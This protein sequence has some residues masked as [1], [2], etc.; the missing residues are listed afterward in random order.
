MIIIVSAYSSGA[1]LPGFFLERHHQCIHVTTKREWDIARLRSYFNADSFV[2]NYIIDN[3]QEFAAVLDELK[4]HDIKAILPGCES[5]VELF[6][7]LCSYFSVPAND[8]QLSAARRNKYLMIEA[9]KKHGLLHAKQFKSNDLTELL[10]WFKEHAK[11][12]VVLKPLSSSSSDGV[13]YCH[14]EAEITN[15]FNLI[16]HQL[17]MY[18]MVNH[19][20]L[21]Q[22]FLDGDEYIVNS[23]SCDGEHYVVDIWKGVSEDSSIVSNDI[24][25]DLVSQMADEYQQLVDY[26]F[27]VLDALGIKNGPAHSEVRITRD[28]PCLI[29][30]GARLAGKVDFSVINTIFGFSQLSLT[31]EVILTP[32]EFKYRIA[33]KK[34]NPHKFARYV[35]FFS[36]DEGWI[37]Q[38]PDLSGI[39]ALESVASVQFIYH[40]G[41]YLKKTSKATK[42]PR[43]GY[44]YLVADTQEQLERDYAALRI[45][46][47][48][49]YAAI[50][51]D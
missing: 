45:A 50:L 20:V 19:E 46:E 33:S 38:E 23:V 13:F 35:Y 37:K 14:N 40:K 16:M 32:D 41:Q 31:G 18:H 17:D 2:K 28:G 9:I 11:S 7:K 44:A 34:N 39:V 1:S 4:K 5:G 42:G 12:R 22:E 6:D 43:P 51:S 25:A 47:R 30:T 29:E 49:L 3:D 36:N 10:S 24:Y 26:V 27:N 21:M 48:K 8:F 15:A